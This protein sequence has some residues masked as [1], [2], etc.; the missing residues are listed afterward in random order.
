MPAGGRFEIITYKRSM[1]RHPPG[2]SHI[3][4]GR[5]QFGAIAGS[6]KGLQ[7]LVRHAGQK[8]FGKT[9]EIHIMSGD[10]HAPDAQELPTL[11]LAVKFWHLAG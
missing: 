6:S 4:V 3:L 7:F 11:F 2:K 10:A 1:R 5:L 8:I 9:I